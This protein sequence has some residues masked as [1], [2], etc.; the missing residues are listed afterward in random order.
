MDRIRSGHEALPTSSRDRCASRNR[1]ASKKSQCEWSQLPFVENVRYHHSPLPATKREPAGSST[2]VLSLGKPLIDLIV[3][4]KSWGT[5]E[6][7][8]VS[9]RSQV[10]G[11]EQTWRHQNFAESAFRQSARKL[12]LVRQDPQDS[13]SQEHGCQN[14]HAQTKSPAENHIGELIT[15]RAINEADDHRQREQIPGGNNFGEQHEST[16]FNQQHDKAFKDFLPD[17]KSKH[18]RA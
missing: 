5:I 3:C 10:K 14:G 12:Q 8:K 17:E 13:K 16:S 15:A 1:R 4:D 2:L 9:G 11:L 18:S 6:S 7:D